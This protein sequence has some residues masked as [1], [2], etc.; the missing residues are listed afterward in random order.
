MKKRIGQFPSGIARVLVVLGLVVGIT[1]ASGINPEKVFA[2]SCPTGSVTWHTEDDANGFQFNANADNYG[3][4]SD[5]CFTYGTDGQLTL[6]QTYGTSTTNPTSYPNDGYG[7]G[8]SECSYGWASELWSTPTMT[9][10]GSMS[11]SGVASGSKYDDLVD[12]LFTTSTGDFS[13]IN[14]EVEVVTYAA[15][16]YSGLGF[17][18]STTCGATSVT[19][20]GNSYWL[21]EK[22]AGTSPTTWPDYI[23]VANTM[24]Q[25]ISS[26]PLATFY[27]DA[28]SSGLG[29][30]LGT[31]NLGF[32]GYGNE[33]WKSGTGLEINSVLATN[34]P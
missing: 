2:V 1:S 15:P 25:S 24:T 3:S 28:N 17:C 9:L 19:V 18:T 31:L 5:T 34:R 13:T 26:L 10:T 20:G 23:F 30:G 21:T 6:T 33:L 7:C 11:N 12:S 22:T 8:V 14:A 16:S 27:S 4:G 29:S 32:V